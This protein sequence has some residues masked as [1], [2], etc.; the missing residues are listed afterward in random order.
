MALNGM[1]MEICRFLLFSQ[2]FNEEAIYEEIPDADDDD[3]IYDDVDVDQ[4]QMMQYLQ[5]T[6]QNQQQMEDNE[7][8]L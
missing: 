6:G 8:V 5:E 3:D 2:N 7:T 1:K 4:T